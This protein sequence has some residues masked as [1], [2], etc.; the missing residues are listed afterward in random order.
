MLKLLIQENGYDS[1]IDYK[2]AKYIKEKVCFVSMDY[3]FEI[4]NI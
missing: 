2:V 3:S 1:N 4:N